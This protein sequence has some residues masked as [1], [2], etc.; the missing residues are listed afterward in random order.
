M[1][2][3]EKKLVC[4]AA[5]IISEYG[6]SIPAQSAKEKWK[7]PSY[8]LCLS[9]AKVRN[10]PQTAVTRFADCFTIFAEKR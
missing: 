3:K 6:I 9:A 1:E 8:S 5:A 4:N 7:I 2:E 10:N